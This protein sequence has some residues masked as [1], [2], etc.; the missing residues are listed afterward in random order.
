VDLHRLFDNGLFSITDDFKIIVSKK[1]SDGP[2]SKID[3]RSLRLAKK[4]HDQPSKVAL[5]HH[6]QDFFVG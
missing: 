4:T 3:G 1:L 5:G 6:R 2:Y